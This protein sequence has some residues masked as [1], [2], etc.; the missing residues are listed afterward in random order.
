MKQFQKDYGEILEQNKVLLP[1]DLSLSMLP[2]I[3]SPEKAIRAINFIQRL[4]SHTKGKW[5][6]MPFHLLTWQFVILWRLFG[7]CKPDGNRQYRTTYCEIPKKNG[8]SELAAAIALILLVA[9]DEQGAEVYSA[10][11]DINQAGLVYAVSAQMVRNNKTLSKRL[12]VLDSRKRII[13][14]KTNSFYQVLS[15]EVATKHG[16]N[17]SGIIFDELHA[18]PNRNLWDVLTEGTDYARSQQMVFTITTAGVYDPNSICWEIREHARQ[19]DEGTIQDDSFLPVLYIA[20]KEKEDY[21]DPKLW[22]RVNPSI[23]R[24]F[25][26]DHIAEDYEKVKQR[27]ARLNN[28]L[29]FRLNIWVNQL[30]RWIDMTAWDDCK[31]KIDPG[32]LIGRECFAGLDTSTKID[33]TALV[34]AFPPEDDGDKWEI[35]C[36]TYCPDDTIMRRSQEDRVPYNLWR[37]A[38]YLTATPGNVVDESFI[39]ADILNFSKIYDLKEVAYDPWNASSIATDLLETHGIQMVEHRQGYASMSEPSKE[40]EKLILSKKLRHDGNPVLRWCVDNLAVT[41]D[42]AGNC[43][44]AKDK[45]RERIDAAV[46]SIMAVGRAIVNYEA[47]SVYEDRG[48]IV[49]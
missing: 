34:L 15:A 2:K 19:I 37:D 39:K 3:T 6:G 12:R 8:K 20:D 29:R 18:Q 13:D 27:P 16:L 14:Y 1:D 24:I 44:P 4:C 28:F 38:G 30:S 26:L 35:I 32:V 10:A 11:A 41:T 31:G 23:G 43:K 48:F 22:K 33:L 21:E 49:L 25:T 36:K 5:A 46:A 7:Q 9:D 40:F 42:A 17:P 47:R 45:A